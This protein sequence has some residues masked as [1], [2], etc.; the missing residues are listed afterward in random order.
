MIGTKVGETGGSKTRLNSHL[1]HQHSQDRLNPQELKILASAGSVQKSC[2]LKSKG[3]L[4]AHIDWFQAAGDI[5]AGDLYPL[6][7]KV[8]KLTGELVHL[9]LG[10]PT[11]VGNEYQN[12]GR[13]LKSVRFAWNN[14][15]VNGRC[16]VLISVPGKVLSAMPMLK[17]RELALEVVG[18]GLKCTR[19]D[20]TVDDYGKRLNFLTLAE[21][22]LSEN[23]AKFRAWDF[24]Y[25]CKGGIS[26]KLGSR[27][28]ARST[29]IYDK[30]IESKG[31]I[32]AY[33]IET[34][35]GAKVAMDVLL[36]W[37]MID[38][39]EL[40]DSWETESAK[41]L[42]QSVVGS[43]DFIDR[44]SK[45]NEK[46]LKRIPRLTWWQ[47][48]V[49]LMEGE[50]YHTAK[51]IQTTLERKSKWHMNQA[52]RSLVSAMKGFGERG[53]EWLEYRLQMA[54]MT[55]KPVHLHQIEQFKKEYELYADEADFWFGM[56]KAA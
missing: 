16:Q 42:A 5:A 46:N 2:D 23:Y 1:Q 6:F 30:A 10:K 52:F 4:E 8:E 3:K 50:I 22:L 43:V 55:L 31:K 34:K 12:S 15:D 19:F 28:S 47:E 20:G 49:T 38:P 39:D 48:F 45:P 13:S 14:Q 40:G 44:Q 18:V 25:S 27:E 33:R 53:S 24:R 51:V 35:F 29:T 32:N 37:L 21:T 9:R 26:F 54:E 11:Q 41:Y 36:G 56:P 7:A 17:V